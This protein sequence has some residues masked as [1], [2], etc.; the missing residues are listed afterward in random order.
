M[1]TALSAVELGTIVATLLFGVGG[2]GGFMYWYLR[3]QELDHDQ[4]IEV[5][6]KFERR[7]LRVEDRLEATKEEVDRLK[8]R[9]NKLVFQINILVKRI[10]LLVDKLDG[11]GELSKKEKEHLTD[12]PEFKGD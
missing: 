12:L 11:Y 4:E 1:F 3:K 6:D 7:L 10:E 2:G 5:S 8:D 9:E